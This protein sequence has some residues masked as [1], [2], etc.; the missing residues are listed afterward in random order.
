[1]LSPH[2]FADSA[3]TICTHSEHPRLLS[4]QH[5][6]LCNRQFS[7]QSSHAQ[8]KRR[9]FDRRLHQNRWDRLPISPA[10]PKKLGHTLRKSPKSGARRWRGWCGP[11]FTRAVAC[12]LSDPGVGHADRPRTQSSETSALHR[13]GGGRPASS[14][15]ALN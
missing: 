4:D 5:S 9:F 14:L 11:R 15:D 2:A 8:M 1:M 10:P 12:S 7:L 6:S 13:L 3:T